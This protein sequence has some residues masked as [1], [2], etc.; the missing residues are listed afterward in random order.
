MAPKSIK[1]EN[2]RTV[3]TEE[4]DLLILKVIP[5]FMLK[6]GKTPY[7]LDFHTFVKNKVHGK[8][9]FKQLNR[10]I[11]GFK[12][13]YGKEG[14]TFTK[15]HEKKALKLFKNIDW[16]TKGGSKSGSK[17]AKKENQDLSSDLVN[18]NSGT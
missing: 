18:F 5:K 17:S 1:E 10:K 11:R 7:S 8:I 6:T 16:D 2:Q 4:D 3:F 9:S 15:T 12:T 14:N 13:K